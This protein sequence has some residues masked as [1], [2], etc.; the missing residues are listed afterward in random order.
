MANWDKPA[1]EKVQE[2]HK[3]PR[4]DAFIDGNRGVVRGPPRSMCVI[5]GQTQKN[6]AVFPQLPIGDFEEFPA[7]LKTV[8]T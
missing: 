8:S 6:R 5:L 3:L 2:N 4:R 1:I 7:T